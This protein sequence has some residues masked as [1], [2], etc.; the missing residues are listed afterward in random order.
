MAPQRVLGLIFV[1]LG[2]MLIVIMT[3]NVG[4]EAI[5]AVIGAGFLF[6]YLATRSYGLLIPGGI[7]TGLGAGIIVSSLGFHGSSVVLGLGAGFLSIAL[8]DQLAGNGRDGWW[9]PLIPGAILVTIGGSEFAGIRNLT[10]YV[11]PAVFI[12][13]G[14]VLLFGRSHLRPPRSQADEPTKH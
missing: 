9:W 1:A 7:L 4:A 3:T 13:L 5:V 8:I 2:A 6:A 10:Q 14:I 11:L 12:G